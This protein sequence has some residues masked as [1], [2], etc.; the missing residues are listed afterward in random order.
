[1]AGSAL[2]LVAP[3]A[4]TLRGVRGCRSPPSST[5]CCPAGLSLR[6]SL[7]GNGLAGINS[8]FMA[9]ASLSWGNKPKWLFDT[10]V[11]LLP[12]EPWLSREEAEEDVEPKLTG[13]S[14]SDSSMVFSS[15]EWEHLA[16]V[17]GSG[18]LVTA[19]GTSGCNWCTSI[20]I[21]KKKRP[22]IR[23]SK[24]FKRISNSRFKGACTCTVKSQTVMS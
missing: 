5:L 7:L 17:V 12:K 19:D 3:L 9:P 18:T 15:W 2:V 24:Y 22:T 21:K 20:H 11:I 10:K 4:S 1:M 8:S 23:L 13:R 6:S 14:L 16:V